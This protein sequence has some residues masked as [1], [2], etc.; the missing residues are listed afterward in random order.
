M[1]R[2]ALDMQCG[3]SLAPGRPMW[4]RSFITSHYNDVFWFRQHLC[5][6]QRQHTENTNNFDAVMALA[7]GCD[8]AA[9]SLRVERPP[10][11]DLGE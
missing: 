6:Q 8:G 11:A 5:S 3:S 2:R 9:R 1:R 4:I 7:V 10:S